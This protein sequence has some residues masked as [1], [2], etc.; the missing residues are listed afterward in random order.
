MVRWQTRT[1]ET[2]RARLGAPKRLAYGPSPIEGLDLYPAKSPNAPIFIF[3]HGGR[4]LF[5]KSK[6]YG[7]PADLFVNAGVNYV[8]LSSSM[9]ELNYSVT[10]AR[11][12]NS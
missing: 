1:G 2:T 9:T 6:D 12:Q 3:I 10:S 5:G 8:A 7:F 4:W 11:Y